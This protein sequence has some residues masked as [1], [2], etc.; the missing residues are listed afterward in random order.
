M[1]Q[2]SLNPLPAEVDHRMRSLVLKVKVKP[3]ARASSLVQADDGSWFAQVM[4]P[5]VDGRAN[6]E[7]Q[8]LVAKRFKCRRSDVTLRSGASGR[9]KLVRVELAGDD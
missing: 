8:T 3:N 9:I 2:G 1:G 4:S 7:L 5:P 6:A